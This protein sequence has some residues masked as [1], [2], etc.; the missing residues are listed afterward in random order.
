MDQTPF[1]EKYGPWALITGGASGIGAEFGRQLAARGLNLLIVDIQAVMMREHARSLEKDFGVAVRTTVADLSKP[2]FMKKIRPALRGIPVG[3]LVNNAA[4]GSAGEFMK[5]D[6]AEML[7]AIEV[8]CRAPLV[9]TRE[10]GPAMIGRGRGGIVF[11]ASSSALQGTPIVANYAATKAYNL[12]LAEALW[13][14]LRPRGVDVL[15]LCPGA[16]NTPAFAKSGARIDNVPGMPFM[17]PAD[18]VAAALKALGKKPGVVPGRVNGIS[19]FIMT[20]FLSRR[21]AVALTGKN[22]RLLYPGR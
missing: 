8:N 17:E 9:L 3:L 18:V 4:W 7:R 12:M 15:A 11:L 20:R 5:T 21:R 2:D 19:S 1:A 14:E 10:L 22:T 13:D 6:P 16:T